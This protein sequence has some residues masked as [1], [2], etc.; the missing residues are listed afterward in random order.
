MAI[1]VSIL[2]NGGFFP[3]IILLTLYYYHRGS[4]SNAMKDE[5]EGY[6]PTG[7]MRRKLHALEIFKEK[8]ERI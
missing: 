7:N 2:Y 6:S 4:R 5:K 1:N 3:D 8:S